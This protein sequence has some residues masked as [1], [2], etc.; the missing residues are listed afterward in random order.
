MVKHKKKTGAIAP[1]RQKRVNVK[2]SIPRNAPA[3]MEDVL[4]LTATSL[5]APSFFDSDDV[6]TTVNQIARVFVRAPVRKRVKSGKTVILK[7]RIINRGNSEDYFNLTTS[8]LLNWSI[9]FP[10]GDTVGPLDPRERSIIP[11]KVLVPANAKKG[12]T[13]TVK[14]TAT[15]QSDPSVSGSSASSLIVR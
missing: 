8:S 4:T 9:E 10:Q 11:I 1:G 6:T 3:N 15:S 14:I 12:D 7:A 13:D 2:V 5:S